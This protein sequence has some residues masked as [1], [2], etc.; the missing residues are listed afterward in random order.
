VVAVGPDGTMTQ[1]SQAGALK[2][3]KTVK[4]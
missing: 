3:K 2:V 1:Y 4:K